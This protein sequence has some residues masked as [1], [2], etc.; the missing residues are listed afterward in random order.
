ML[1]IFIASLYFENRD[2]SSRSWASEIPSPICAFH[3]VFKNKGNDH[4]K[5]I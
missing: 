4:Q 3:C 5:E 1:L 2:G